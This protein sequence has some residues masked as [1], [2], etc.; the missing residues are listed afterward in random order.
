MLHA[1]PITGVCKRKNVIRRGLLVA[2]RRHTVR[3]V[4]AGTGLPVDVSISK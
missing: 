4:Q 1:T 3:F 2:A